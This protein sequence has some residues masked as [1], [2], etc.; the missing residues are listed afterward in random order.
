MKK[1]RSTAMSSV[2]FVEPGHIVWRC[3]S[4]V[5]DTTANDNMSPFQ[6]NR[7]ASDLEAWA[8][9]KS[10]NPNF[11]QV[12]YAAAVEAKRMRRQARLDIHRVN[13]GRAINRVIEAVS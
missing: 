1:E 5:R 8:R 10:D 12:C 11:A 9:S 3:F 6:M 4:Q 13:V 7:I 2:R